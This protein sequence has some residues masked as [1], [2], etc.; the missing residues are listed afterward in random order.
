[1]SVMSWRWP[2]L[3]VALLAAACA[4]DERGYEHGPVTCPELDAGPAVDPVLL[5][6][7]SGARSAHHAA[8]LREQSGDLP[9][10]TASLESL[11]AGPKPAG[12]RPEVDEVLSDTHARLA[13]LYSRQGQMPRAFASIEAG[14][15]LAPKPTY[16]RG[17]LFEVRGLLEERQAETLQKEG[18]DLDSKRARERALSAFEEAMRIQ[19]SV[20]EN[21]APGLP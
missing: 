17:H 7:L 14:L 16:F 21:S 13:E 1:M 3:A 11:I 18:K 15:E 20:I 8:D 5:G 6:F 10:A 19:K 2:L 9:G 4:K 12:A